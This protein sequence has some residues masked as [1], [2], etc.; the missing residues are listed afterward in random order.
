MCT[1]QLTPSHMHVHREM[2]GRES[3]SDSD[4]ERRPHPQR[5]AE[6]WTDPLARDLKRDRLGKKNGR[7]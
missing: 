1:I 3:D 4:K 5:G 2:R 7:R 6:D